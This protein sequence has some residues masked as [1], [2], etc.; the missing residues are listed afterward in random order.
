MIKKVWVC[1][2][3][4]FKYMS[5]FLC[6][7][8]VIYCLSTPDSTHFNQTLTR[9]CGLKVFT[10]LKIDLMKIRKLICFRHNLAMLPYCLFL[11]V[12]PT[13]HRKSALQHTS[14]GLLDITQYILNNINYNMPLFRRC[15][16]Y[17]VD[18]F[19]LQIASPLLALS[20]K[21]PAYEEVHMQ[22]H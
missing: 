22:T 5:I 3:S 10:F 17:F 19:Q 21:T 13:V 15:V 9:S 20:K 11:I 7:A 18:V 12:P 14:S 6:P 1:S 2:H 4:P 8:A 16:C